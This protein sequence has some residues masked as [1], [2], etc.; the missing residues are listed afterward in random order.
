[1]SL[2]PPAPQ[3]IVVFGASGDLARRK[4]IPALYNLARDDLLPTRCRVIGFARTE[5]STEEFRAQA[6]ASI[7]VSPRS[8]F[9]EEAW[10]RFAP[11]LSYVSG[12]FD[13]PAA[14]ARLAEQL[15]EADTLHGCEGGRLYYLAVPPS[16]FSHVVQGLGKI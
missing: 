1:M 2:R 13:D 10:E 6:R 9:D 4:I 16:A 7:Q 15:T 3:A 14:M 12:S 5:W 11:A 8:G